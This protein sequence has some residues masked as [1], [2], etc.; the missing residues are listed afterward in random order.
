MQQLLHLVGLISPLLLK[1]V[2]LEISNNHL[3]V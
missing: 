1:V 3:I 2:M